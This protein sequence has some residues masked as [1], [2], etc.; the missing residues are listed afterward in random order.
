MDAELS[1]Y[2]NTAKFSGS[3]TNPYHSWQDPRLSFLEGPH[4]YLW[5]GSVVRLSAT[6]IIKKYFPGFDG[7]AIVQRNWA[8]WKNKNSKYSALIRYL[9]QVQEV[10]ERTAQTAV[11]AL[12]DSDKNIA[13][14]EGTA[15]HNQFECILRAQPVLRPMPEC[16]QFHTW[17]NRFLEQG[18]WEVFEPEYKVVKLVENQAHTPVWAGAIDLVLKHRKTPGV[19]CIIDYKH[20]DPKDGYNLIG[21]QAPSR[22]SNGVGTG[23][24]AQI[25]NSDTGKYEV[26]LNIYAH[27]LHTDYGM[28]ARDHM[29]VVQVHHSLDAPNV[30]HVPRYDDAM[31]L[32]TVVETMDAVT[33]SQAEAPFAFGSFGTSPL[34]EPLFFL[35]CPSSSPPPPPS[36]KNQFPSPFIPAP[37]NSPKYS[38]SDAMKLA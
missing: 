26:Q 15:M 16:T 8:A 7:V 37:P 22:F 17:L 30:H 21:K 14:S 25:S 3:E 35:P 2:A 4:L 31:Q 10:D 32:M 1:I 12:W 34:K 6:G 28:D 19:Y 33:E 9:M 5:E 23:P 38:H 24:F 11:L 29:Y 20:T 27:T 13:A 18:G 36:P